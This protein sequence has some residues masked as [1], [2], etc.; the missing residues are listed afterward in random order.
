MVVILDFGSQYTQLIARRI[1]EAG[2]YCE[3]HPFSISEDK[4]RAMEPAAV[5][6]SGSPASV[7]DDDAPMPCEAALDSGLGVPTLGICYGMCVAATAAGGRVD[8]ASKREYGRADLTVS[9]TEDLFYGFDAGTATVV[10]MSHGDKLSTP[11]SDWEVIASSHNSP[12]AAMRDRRRNLYTLQFH[13][14]VVH[15]DRGRQILDNF[16]FRICGLQADWTMDS[17][18]DTAIAKV[19]DQVGD[20]HVICG[21]SGGV[22][23][24][25][26]AA[27]LERA[28]PGQLTGVFVNNGLLRKDEGEQVRDALGSYFKTDLLYVDA[29]DRFLDALAGVVDPERKRKIIGRTFIEVFEEAAH[30]SDA[31]RGKA[32]F[33]AQGTLYPDVIE[34]VSVRGPS[35]TIK[36]HHNVGGLPE[37]MKLELV[38]PLRELFK[39]EVRAVGELLELPRD[40]IRRHPF[41]GPGLAVR[42]LG[43]VNREDLDILREADAIYIE[44]L[45]RAGIYDEIWQ[46]FAVLLPI[47]TVGVQGD[48]RTYDRVIALRAVVSQDGMTADWYR[49]PQEVLARVSSRISNEV[50][51]V[52]RIAYDVSS[53]P[54][55]T[56]EWE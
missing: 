41:P 56:V 2:V 25:V 26:T 52:N 55:A 18:L 29:S 3:I 17:F 38:E 4:L 37:K 30:E 33:L 9:S 54:P 28:V 6:L 36:S 24:T 51:G 49:F 10:W 48:D 43:D 16:L 1:R 27:L 34:S 12:F 19:R 32:R 39:D 8:P 22:D 50:Q 11:P 53:K 23:S 31:T 21:I 46:A 20:G 45:H 15:T 40:F 42:V 44:E 7:Y 47:R 35:S 14:E 5:V 13:P